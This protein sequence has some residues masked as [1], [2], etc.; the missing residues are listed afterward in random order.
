[1]TK[2]LI[3]KTPKLPQ[4]ESNRQSELRWSRS[5]SEGHIPTPTIQD[6]AGGFSWTGERAFASDRNTG[7][8]QLAFEE[9]LDEIN[10]FTDS[11]IGTVLDDKYKILSVLGFGGMSVIY[12]AEQILIEKLVAIKT[13]KFRVDERPVIWRRFER[14]VKTLSRLSH[15]NIV[16]IYDC[17][18]GDNGQPYVVMDYISGQSLDQLLHKK[19]RLSIKQMLSIASQVCAAVGHAHRNNVIHR[20]IKP[21]NIMLIEQNPVSAPEGETLASEAQ[22]LVKVVDFGLA[23]LG[24]DS[25][26]LTQTGELWGS[27]PYMSPEQIVGADCDGRADIY[28]LG[29]VLFEMATGRDP[30]ADVNVYK[31][32]HNH[33]NIQ[34]PELKDVCPDVDFPAHLQAVIAKALAKNPQERFATMGDFRDSLEAACN[35]SATAGL[36]PPAVRRPGQ[37]AFR[38]QEL[39]LAAGTSSST[40]NAA[41]IKSDGGTI[42]AAIASGTSS[43][44]VTGA[45]QLSAQ[46]TADAAEVS[47]TGGAPRLS[48]QFHDPNMYSA[49]T[50]TGLLI[51]ACILLVFNEVNKPQPYNVRRP[52]HTISHT[53]PMAP[54][55][56]PVAS[57]KHNLVKHRALPKSHNTPLRK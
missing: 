23:K 22:Y 37:T 3:A 21:A 49:W 12:K 24:E 26:K 10:D 7:Q 51:A 57:L 44:A 43:F 47:A 39:R 4:S 48:G 32:L 36:P 27:P 38:L 6:V 53:I 14:E 17:V 46:L 45:S 9:A 8:E 13:V 11:M 50:V 28:S 25:R 34:A 16:T 56:P 1:M 41:L 55:P 35:Y 15:P 40:A 42:A 2:E 52:Y 33:L 5:D 19:G 54:V 29:C 31:L 30:F 18:I 20:D